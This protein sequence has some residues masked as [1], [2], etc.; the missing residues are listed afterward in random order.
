MYKWPIRAWRDANITNGEMQIK[1]TMRYHLTPK[2]VAIIKETENDTC[3]Q[4][5]EATWILLHCW[6]ERQWYSCCRKQ[7]G[8]FLKKLMSYQTTQQ[9]HFWIYTQK[10]ESRV[11]KI[12]LYSNIDCNI[13][14]NSENIEATQVS[15]N[16]SAK[17]SI[18]TM[19]TMQP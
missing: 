16:G 15:I 11:S 3:W 12:H 1:T 17:R 18:R 19:G 4:G 10:D 6:W 2:R 9:F 8:R 5:C 14:H 7:D 13:I